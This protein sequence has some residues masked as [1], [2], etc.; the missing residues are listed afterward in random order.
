MDS[1][2][3]PGSLELPSRLYN[4]TYQNTKMSTISS[5][6]VWKKHASFVFRI[7]GEECSAFF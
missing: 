7:D 3:S 5:I 2:H 4:V 6:V 1:M